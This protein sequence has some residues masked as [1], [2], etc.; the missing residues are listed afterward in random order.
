MQRIDLTGKTFGDWKVREY[1]LES[2]GSKWICECECGVVKS[3]NGQSLRLGTSRSCATC[4]CKRARVEVK[5]SDLPFYKEYTLMNQRLKYGK[6]YL[7]HAVTAALEFSTLEGFSSWM[8]DNLPPHPQNCSLDLIDFTQ[9]FGPGNLE[10]K[11]KPARAPKIDLTS[12]EAVKALYESLLAE[13]EGSD[14][15]V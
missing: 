12:L 4:M 3:V 5:K 14:D 10:W 2:K 1:D 9:P 13:A 15:A 11:E 7:E 6:K 8:E